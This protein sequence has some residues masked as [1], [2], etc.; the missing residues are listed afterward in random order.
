[1]T[2]S[3][4]AERKQADDSEVVLNERKKN[5]SK[6]PENGVQDVNN[7]ERYNKAKK[8]KHSY[9]DRKNP[10][11]EPKM[12][13]KVYK[14][15]Q[16][17]LPTQTVTTSNSV[18]SLMQVERKSTKPLALTCTV[19][20]QLSK[21]SK[22]SKD[23][24]NMEDKSN[25]PSQRV[26]SKAII[27]KR[28]SN[29]EPMKTNSKKSKT[30]AS[31]KGK[32]LVSGKKT[33]NGIVTGNRAAVDSDTSSSQSS[34]ESSSSSS[35]LTE[36]SL[37]T[38]NNASSLAQV[39]RKST[40]ALALTS[41][42]VTQLSKSS[43]PSEEKSHMKDKS[44][45]PSQRFSSKANIGKRKSNLEPMKTNSKKS[46]TNTDSKGKDLVSG[47]KTLNGIVT[48][49]RIA[50]DSNTSSSQSSTESSSS[51]STESSSESTDE[52]GPSNSH[53]KVNSTVSRVASAEV[54]NN[55]KS[56]LHEKFGK[57]VEHKIAKD[58]SA[59]KT[60]K[61]ETGVPLKLHTKSKGNGTLRESSSS[62]ESST[63]T[64]KSAVAVRKNTRASSSSSSSTESKKEKAK[65]DS[66]NNNNNK[67]TS[68]SLL[69]PLLSSPSS[70]SFPSPSL[71][72]GIQT[73][74]TNETSVNQ[75]P[76]HC[77]TE[78]ISVSRLKQAQQS[79]I[80]RQKKKPGKTAY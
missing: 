52:S 46:K 13:K 15:Y 14:K 6:P 49:N 53:S 66:N 72:R 21:S 37:V 12:A 40:K 24:S 17:N 44:N 77:I 50:V 69:H 48:G 30:S 59:R 58:S 42:V 64:D 23:K 36:S 27:G 29:L 28:K 47:K 20:T 39:E 51:S 71:L 26:L 43:R 76:I 62:S 2:S 35:S 68:S 11:K 41:T 16:P 45:N 38:S 7:S 31:S 80:R 3:N 32:D 55:D 8:E 61:H 4:K 63:D 78:K 65:L 33:L 54:T 9:K 18:S 1:M 56:P 22:P 5:R 70:Q 25:N 34:T 79:T 10:V 57:D 19:D 75:S 67:E 73:Q 60:G 74:N